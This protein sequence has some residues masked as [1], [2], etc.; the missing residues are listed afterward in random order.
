MVDSKKS[1][2]RPKRV[3]DV[4]T[5]TL[6]ERQAKAVRGGSTKIPG[7]LKWQSITLKRGITGSQ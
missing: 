7:R 4:K 2:K 5:R 6:G 1:G 3:K